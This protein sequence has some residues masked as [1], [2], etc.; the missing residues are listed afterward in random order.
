MFGES[1]G[2]MFVDCGDCGG[3]CDSRDSDD[4]SDSRFVTLTI[5]SR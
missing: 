1:M 5:H 4:S 3:S 2:R